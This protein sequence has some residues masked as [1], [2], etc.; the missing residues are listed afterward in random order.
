M[1]MTTYKIKNFEEKYKE[2]YGNLRND[3][4]N[5]FEIHWHEE[6]SSTMDLV[7]KNISNKENLNHIIVSNY[8]RDVAQDHSFEAHKNYELC[9]VTFEYILQRVDGEQ[10]PHR[11]ID[12]QRMHPVV[13]LYLQH[14]EIAKPAK[15]MHTSLEAGNFRDFRLDLEKIPPKILTKMLNEAPVLLDYPVNI[16][17]VAVT[18][19]RK[20]VELL[21]DKGWYHVLT[22]VRCL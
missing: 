9:K 16:N 17:T 4:F 6:L 19:G 22:S 8:Q 1:S 14:P 21:L 11:A 2:K 7:N 12:M 20:F 13:Q 3:I 10:E 15:L 5:N 18:K